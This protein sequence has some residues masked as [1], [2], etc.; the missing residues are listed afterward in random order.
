[1][2]SKDKKDETPAVVTDTAQAAPVAE[3][4][5]TEDAEKKA[6]EGTCNPALSALENIGLA[7]I[8][9]H[10]FREV[11]VTSDGLVFPLHNDAQQ[12]AADLAGKHIIKVTKP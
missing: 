6:P 11:Y 8:E 1:M 12:H 5:K 9:R 2:T 4:S 7:A 3:P 10:G